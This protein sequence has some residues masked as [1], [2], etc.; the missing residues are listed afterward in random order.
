MIFV[1]CF[2]TVF[3][4]ILLRKYLQRIHEQPG[5]WTYIQGKIEPNMET[6]C[7]K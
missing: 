3:Q 2:P 6:N 5:S 1:K 4:H 7:C